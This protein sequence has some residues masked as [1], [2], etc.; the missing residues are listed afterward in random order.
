MMDN[1]DVKDIR[2]DFLVCQIALAGIWAHLRKDRKTE[3][4]LWM[5]L[6]HSLECQIGGANDE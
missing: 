4:K 1:K 3:N 2:T 6:G 5:L